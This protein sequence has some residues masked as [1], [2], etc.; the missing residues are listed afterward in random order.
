MILLNTL[1]ENW[2]DFEELK[3][4]W[5][6]NPDE[7]MAD[8][9]KY[10]K[11][12]IEHYRSI[13]SMPF[14]DNQKIPEKFPEDQMLE[15]YQREYFNNT[16]MSIQKPDFNAPF[17]HPLGSFIPP[18]KCSY[19][20]YE[21]MATEPY[22]KAVS[23]DINKTMKVLS[24]CPVE[25]RWLDF[26]PTQYPRY[27]LQGYCIKRETLTGK[28]CKPCDTHRYTV[29]RHNCQRGYCKWFGVRFHRLQWC[30][31]FY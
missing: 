13:P 20:D 19:I 6:Y 28:F 8:Y 12:K 23:I 4:E 15:K 9:E 2:L 18:E 27:I 24:L 31:Q 17:K 1:A 30:S 25:Y 7:E 10:W 16:F 5:K 29:L 3:E 11:H 22:N 21:N 26:G 14:N